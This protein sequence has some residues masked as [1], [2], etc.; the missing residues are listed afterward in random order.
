MGQF[1]RAGFYTVRLDEP[2][3]LR[4]GERFAAAVHIRTPGAVHPVAIE[5]GS[6]EGEITA[7]VDLSDGEGYISS[8]GRL[9]SRTE[10]EQ[11][12]KVCLKVYTRRR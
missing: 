9:W 10:T 6:G 2:V 5:F 11:A 8:D 12:S 1:D 3:D 4:P 7:G